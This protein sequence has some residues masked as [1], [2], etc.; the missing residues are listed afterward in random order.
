MLTIYRTPSAV[1]TEVKC[2]G[3]YKYLGI[4]LGIKK[5]VNHKAITDNV[6]KLIFNIDGVPLFKSSNTQAWPI[7]CQINK[8]QIFV[9]ALYTGENKPTPV[10]EYLADFIDELK[11]LLSQRIVISH[12]VYTLFL[13]V[14]LCDAPARSFLK[15]TIG[16]IGYWS[17]ER[18]LV[19]GTWSGR[20]VF[21]G[22]EQHSL[23]TDNDFGQM[24]YQNHQ[25][26]LS[27]MLQLKVR[28]VS[29][30]PLDYM[31][32]VCLGAVRRIIQFWKKG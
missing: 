20:V 18:C 3:T 31:H 26:G 23:R 8:G 10:Q 12:H 1:D 13:V 7:L 19:K 6:I 28:C 16:H 29:M 14:F 11:S 21:N 15:C 2:G 9:V 4:E 30:F 27:P 25:K 24:L 22:E 32:F 17:C 5:Y